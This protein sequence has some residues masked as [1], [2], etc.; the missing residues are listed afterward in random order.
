MIHRLSASF[1]HVSF[2]LFVGTARTLLTPR[3]KARAHD[4]SGMRTESIPCFSLMLL[5]QNFPVSLRTTFISNKQTTPYATMTA[6]AL[7]AQ[8]YRREAAKQARNVATRTAPAAQRAV[9]H[10]KANAVV[11]P[12][13]KAAP[14]P[15]ADTKVPQK[16]KFNFDVGAEE[17]LWL[18]V[19]A[20]G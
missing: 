17:Y 20:A 10:P 2:L 3:V 1:S 13:E 4:L 5:P 6:G 15:N 14:T 11:K 16:K 12:A 8:M 19:L 18:G 7:F 9:Q